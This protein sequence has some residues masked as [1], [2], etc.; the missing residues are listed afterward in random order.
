MK[1]FKTPTTLNT[2][3]NKLNNQQDRD[4]IQ[5]TPQ[6]QLTLIYPKKRETEAKTF[7]NETINQLLEIIEEMPL[8]NSTVHIIIND[9]GR[10]PQYNTK[11]YGG[12]SFRTESYLDVH[13]HEIY[14][15]LDDVSGFQHEWSH[16]FDYDEF[17]KHKQSNNFQMIKSKITRTLY[18]TMNQFNYYN[19]KSLNTKPKHLKYQIGNNEIFARLLNQH[20]CRT[21]E[22]NIYADQI[23]PL[24]VDM[25]MGSSYANDSE[26]KSTVDEFIN[27]IPKINEWSNM[28]RVDILNQTY[29]DKDAVTEFMNT[30]KQITI[31]NNQPQR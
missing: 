15:S 13:R 28:K 23:K 21:H 29:L 20:Y 3:L 8:A 4:T 17:E 26:Y 31:E 19:T 11:P 1:T 24:I 12:E 14:M 9:T 6:T 16:V 2:I 10:V 25:V 18:K 27:E 22:P 30:L 7:I 5:L